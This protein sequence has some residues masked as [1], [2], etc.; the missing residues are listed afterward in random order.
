[1]REFFRPLRRKIGVV[2]LE[3]ACLFMAG[4]TR[5]YSVA[6]MIIGE[7]AGFIFESVSGRIEWGEFYAEVDKELI[8]WRTVD[9]RKIP[10]EY[11]GPDYHN[12]AQEISYP[13]IVIPLTAIS[14][15]LLLSKP[16]TSTSKTITEPTGNDR[17]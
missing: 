14:A 6:D 4:W 15:F 1:M 13:L 9:V 17:A 2:T 7:E 5:S 10:P 3:L 8:E 12:Y 11:Y 16:K